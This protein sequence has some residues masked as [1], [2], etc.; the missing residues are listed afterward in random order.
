MRGAKDLDRRGLAVLR[1][2][3]VAREAWAREAGRPPFKVLASEAMIRLA[4]ERPRTLKALLGVPGCT[5]RVL[6]RYG[7]RLVAALARAQAVPESD[8]PCYPRPQRPRVSPATQRRIEALVAWRAEA[9]GRL[10]LD[11]GLVI[12]RRLIER[13]AEE[14]PATP[15][16]LER[17]E[18]LRRWRVEAFGPAICGVLAACAD[19]TAASKAG[20]ER[21]G[22]A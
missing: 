9:A 14:V 17:V 4:M 1:E 6:Q 16:Q 21:K 19:R 20:G 2:L 5:P 10:G 13:L 12:P 18:G 15:E 11:P 8:L 3:F 22:S 7:D